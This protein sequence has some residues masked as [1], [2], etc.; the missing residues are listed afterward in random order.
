VRESVCLAAGRL[1]LVLLEEEEE[2]LGGAWLR[3]LCS[4][5]LAARLLQLL[6][7]ARLAEEEGQE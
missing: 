5:G 1:L 3:F 7:C 6:G 4:C 2:L